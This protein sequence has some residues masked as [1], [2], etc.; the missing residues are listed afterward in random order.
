M[1][2]PLQSNDTKF[3]H[4]W[5]LGTTFEEMANET[6]WEQVWG[7]SYNASRWMAEAWFEIDPNP[8]YS[9]V[10]DAIDAAFIVGITLDYR[11]TN[12]GSSQIEA[13]YYQSCAPYQCTWFIAY[14]KTF[15]EVMIIVFGLLGGIHAALFV[16]INIIGA[17]YKKV[18]G[19]E[20]A[21]E[22]NDEEDK[23]E[24]GINQ[25]GIIKNTDDNEA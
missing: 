3:F 9:V 10:A 7:L 2:Y 23:L 17:I 4:D 25:T 15:L 22:R 24:M 19:I 16:V 21:H 11:Y 13:A 5:A 18:R 8:I 12:N 20:F 1:V 14:K 6:Y